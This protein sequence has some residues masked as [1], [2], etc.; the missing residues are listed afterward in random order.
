MVVNNPIKKLTH[1]SIVRTSGEGAL[2]RRPIN[3]YCKNAQKKTKIIATVKQISNKLTV[4]KAITDQT[5]LFVCDGL[6]V[7]RGW[8]GGEYGFSDSIPAIVP[9]HEKA[10]PE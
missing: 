4:A 1:I 5:R 9:A 10:P 2:R 8:P 3:G 6:F 7:R